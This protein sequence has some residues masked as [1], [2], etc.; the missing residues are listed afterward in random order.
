MIAAGMAMGSPTATMA[1][2][3]QMMTVSALIAAL[4]RG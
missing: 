4:T 1:Q 2:I 3:T